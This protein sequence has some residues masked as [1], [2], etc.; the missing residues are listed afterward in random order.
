MTFYKHLPDYVVNPVMVDVYRQDGFSERPNLHLSEPVAA[1]P[2]VSAALS[3]IVGL[4]VEAG[5]QKHRTLDVSEEDNWSALTT[6]RSDA[7]DIAKEFTTVAPD[8]RLYAL[9]EIAVMSDDLYTARGDLLF[10]QDLAVRVEEGLT[11]EADE[12]VAGFLAA[13]GAPVI[14]S[15]RERFTV[16]PG[17]TRKIQ[18]TGYENNR[19]D[20]EGREREFL[21]DIPSCEAYM[22]VTARDQMNFGDHVVRVAPSTMFDREVAASRFLQHTMPKDKITPVTSILVNPSGDIK[23]LLSWF[24]G[25]TAE[26]S[27]LIGH[28]KANSKVSKL[29]EQFSNSRAS[30]YAKQYKQATESGLS[31]RLPYSPS[32]SRIAKT[33]TERAAD[34]VQAPFKSLSIIEAFKISENTQPTVL[35]QLKDVDEYLYGDLIWQAPQL[36]PQPGLDKVVWFDGKKSNRVLYLGCTLSSQKESD[37]PL[38]ANRRDVIAHAFFSNASER[39]VHTA[40]TIVET[41]SPENRAAALRDFIT[42]TKAKLN[43]VLVEGVRT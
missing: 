13:T 6:D 43:Y 3:R 30:A 17:T 33:A 4:K 9:G 15:G 19:F 42:T 1:R 28:R 18:I 14:D 8:S 37:G 11:F 20:P 31:D 38:K 21:R 29:V 36:D 2:E 26:I 24:G 27:R 7:L 32:N 12:M 39:H 22:A 41:F 25:D 34:F 10:G 40:K 35:Q 16:A 23:R 5:V